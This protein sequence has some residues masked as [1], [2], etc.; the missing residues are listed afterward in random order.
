MSAELLSSVDGMLKVLAGCDIGGLCEDECSVLVARLARLEKACAFVRSA[1][2]ARA[3]QSA[4][5][6]ARVTGESTGDAKRELDTAAQLDRMPVTPDAVRSGDVSLAQASE[7]AATVAVC[8][9]AEPAMLAT[10]RTSSLRALRDEGRR[11]RHAT[12][13]PGALH[14]QQRATRYHRHWRDELGMIRYSGAMLP[15]HGIPFRH[16][17][18][19]ETDR[20]WRRARRAGPVTDTHD[21]L[22]A[23]AFARVVGGGGDGHSDRADVVYVCDL[24]TG[25]SHIVGGGPVPNAT[26]DRAAKTAF[27]K[28]VVHDGTKVDSVVHYGRRKIPVV[29]RTAIELGDPPRFDG[30]RC[31]DCDRTLGLQW[32]HVD[33]V[34][35]GG[36]TTRANLRPRCYSCHTAKT[37][38]DRAAGLIGPRPK[39]DAGGPSP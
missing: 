33:P 8:P 14:E 17:V 36:P 15:E 30:I 11:R 34:A 24:D 18:D 20:A 39:V 31:A 26:V 32:D 38:R 19:A 1:A 28:A 23:D 37:E 3:G 35:N 27:V 21:Q 22:A 5:Q 4:E 9:N 7:V 12:I 25:R 16:R 6:V 29:V 13:D 2:A 10:A